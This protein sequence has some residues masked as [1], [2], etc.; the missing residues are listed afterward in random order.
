MMW[1]L[2]TL[3]YGVLGVLCAFGYG[4]LGTGKTRTE[5]FLKLMLLGCI[6]VYLMDLTLGRDQSLIKN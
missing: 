3:M 4:S 6:R 2:V 1:L 5:I